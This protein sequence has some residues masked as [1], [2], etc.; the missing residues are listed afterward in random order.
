MIQSDNSVDVISQEVVDK[1]DY[2]LVFGPIL[3]DAKPLV[4]E[5]VTIADVL[6]A[7]GLAQ[8]RTWCRK[9][10]WDWKIPSGYTE[11]KFGMKKVK[12]CM[13][14]AYPTEEEKAAQQ[15]NAITNG[16]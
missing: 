3:P 10:K 5:F 14:V 8:S 12:I 4:G 16:V 15:I 11:V 7:L 1:G 9:N 6:I 2:E 13:L